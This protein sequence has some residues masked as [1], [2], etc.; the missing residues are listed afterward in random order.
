[1]G[2][3]KY[4]VRDWVYIGLFGALWGVIEL[5]LGT[6]LHVL[7]PPMA[8]TFFT[9]IILTFIGCIIA[10]CSRFLVPRRGSILL[11]GVIT[12]LLKLISPG[13]VKIGPIAAILMESILM[14][15]VLLLAPKKRATGFIAA[16]ALALAWSFVHRLVMLRLLYG[17]PFTD[18]T[19][20]IAQGGSRAFGIGEAQIAAVLGLMLLVQIAAG[21]VSGFVAWKLGTEIAGRMEERGDR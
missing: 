3:K 1:M 19:L 9:G 13:G 6:I 10:L 20:K 2:G 21:A 11:I 14:E 18:T 5:S 8:N 16:G 4:T 12:A 17:K 7:F 15:G